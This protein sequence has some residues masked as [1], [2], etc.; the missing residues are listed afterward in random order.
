MNKAIVYIILLLSVIN[1]YNGFAQEIDT[2]SYSFNYKHIS[3][4]KLIDEIEKYSKTKFYYQNEW[5]DTINISLVADSIGFDDLINKIFTENKIAYFTDNHIVY[6][7]FP[8]TNKIFPLPNYSNISNEE[9]EIDNRDNKAINI[10]ERY[11]KGREPD[12]LETIIIGNS[13]KLKPG[14]NTKINGKLFDKETGEPLIG[15]TVYLN[16]LNRGSASDVNGFISLALP[17]GK[18]SADF[19]CLGMEGIKCILDVRSDGYFS[20]P[21]KKGLISLSEV[22]IKASKNTKRSSKVGLEKLSISEI[23]EIPVLLGEKDII[24]VSQMLPG[25][26][27]VSEGAQGVNVRGGNVDQNLFYINNI[28][29]YNSSHLFGFFS[30]FNSNIIKDFTLY[31]AHVPVEY[32]GRLSSVFNI[33]TRK[34]N[35]KKFYT[36]GGVSPIS[37]DIEV[38]TP[39]KKDKISLMVSA[40]S[41]YSDWILKKINEPDIRNSSAKFYDLAGAIDYDIN[42]KNRITLFSYG[43]S[44]YFSL[45]KL[46]NFSYSNFGTSLKFEHRFTP[47]IKSYFLFVVA[48][49]DFT[50]IDKNSPP[51]AF[52]HSYSLL[53]RESKLGFDWLINEKHT[54]SAGINFILYNLDRGDVLPYGI[55]SQRTINRL[56]TEQGVE[57]AVFISDNYKINSKLNIYAGLRYSG[58]TELGPKKVLIYKEN[59]PREETNIEEAV[60]YP[61]GSKIVNYFGPELRLAADYSI[62]MYNSVKLSFTQMR[63][64]LFMLSKTISVA[65]NDQWKLVDSH[66]KPP[67][68]NQVSAGYYKTI[69]GLGLT[70]SSEIYYKYAKQIVEYKDGADFLTNSNIETDILQGNQ[71]AYGIE[72]MIA[73]KEGKLNGWITYT[74]SKSFIT[75]NGN[76]F[77]EK[78]NKGK[79]YPSN[80]D[81]PHVCNIIW[82]YKFNRRVSASLNMVYSTG[83]PITFPQSAYFIQLNPVVYY[84]DRNEF[85]IPDYFRIDFSISL[86][87]NLKKKKLLHGYWNFSIYNLTGRNNVYSIYFRNEDRGLQGYKYSIIGNPIFTVSWN[88]KLGNYA[89]N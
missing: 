5:I 89:S 55:E 62:N 68:S 33:E 69:P 19:Q 51:E 34:G 32:G 45:N 36:R 4:I 38:E 16:E 70:T 31:K 22:V 6:Y 39:L 67:K 29:I 41:T 80:F 64:Y 13:N 26:T 46:T 42:T 25:V 88:F 20:L 7:L 11:L 61:Q 47:G 81:K 54:L 52:K 65:P 79:T 40:R 73:K 8:V 75:V 50:T 44:D 72:F 1:S 24:K 86:E 18:Y 60:N 76:N 87:G 10:Q 49:Y 85:R 48:K 83:R 57:S 37:A 78:I 9:E 12:M 15:A 58:F 23:K 77:W 56:G 59:L 63:Q 2:N 27:S 21:M 53:H 28:P 14:K 35:K 66:I 17:P 74:Y 82:N 71:E 84:S 3:L 30:A 43:S